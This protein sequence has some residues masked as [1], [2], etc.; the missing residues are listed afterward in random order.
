MC[1]CGVVVAVTPSWPYCIVFGNAIKICVPR[2]TGIWVPALR[3]RWMI[4]YLLSRVWYRSHRHG[5]GQPA[6]WIGG[7]VR[8][9]EL[10][11]RGPL[12]AVVLANP[13]K[14][15][16]T[17]RNHVGDVGGQPHDEAPKLLIA[18]RGGSPD[19]WRRDIGGI[20]RVGGERDEGTKRDH[21]LAREEGIQDAKSLRDARQRPRGAEYRPPK[22]HTQDDECQMLQ[23]M[24]L[25]V[26]QGCIIE[27]GRMPEPEVQ[28][29]EA[30]RHDRVGQP[31]RHPQHARSSKERRQHPVRGAEQPEW[32]GNDGKQHMLDHMGAEEVVVAEGV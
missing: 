27:R 8:S 2:G 19:G 29:E 9:I 23:D 28:I 4:R 12:G 25:V 31:L 7:R 1:A 11:R 18:E 10:A 5:R 14:E 17:E 26:G 6:R 13:L 3:S 24:N 16:H 32:R 30:E 21:W 22:E 20:E 15:Q